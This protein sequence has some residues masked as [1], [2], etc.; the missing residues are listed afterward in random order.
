MAWVI[1]IGINHVYLSMPP[2]T[3]LSY[4]IIAQQ[5]TITDAVGDSNWPLVGSDT[6]QG[7]VDQGVVDQMT[8][9]FT[10]M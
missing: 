4:S 5:P 9:L 7:V 1:G 2:A 6:L 10:L 8:L 3:S